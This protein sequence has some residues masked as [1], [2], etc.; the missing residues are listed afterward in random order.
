M[1]RIL[2][3]FGIAMLACSVLNRLE[4]SRSETATPESAASEQPVG[5]GSGSTVYV[6]PF[7]TLIGR[8]DTQT[9]AYG[10]AFMLNWGWKATTRQYVLDY[11]ESAVTKVTFDGEPVTDAGRTDITTDGDVY[12]I[13]WEKNLGVLPRGKY[14]MTFYEKY[15]RKFSDGW[16]EFGPGTDAESVEDTC[17]LIVE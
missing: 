10:G 14:V 11:L 16:S 6:A 7:C 9:E 4:D 5:A 13:F 12:E 15:T 3:V 8:D 17:Y 2:L 1:K